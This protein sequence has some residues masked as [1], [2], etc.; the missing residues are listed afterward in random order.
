MYF[1]LKKTETGTS[2]SLNTVFI[3][4]NIDIRRSVESSYNLEKL[5][6]CFFGFLLN[7]SENFL[8]EQPLVF[9]LPRENQKVST[10]ALEVQVVLGKLQN[11]K[12]N[13]SKLFWRKKIKKKSKT[14]TRHTPK[15]GSMAKKSALF[16][17]VP[18]LG[19]APYGF[20]IIVF[21]LPQLWTNCLVEEIIHSFHGKIFAGNMYL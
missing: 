1:L 8:L 20:K 3:H 21:I 15:Q 5:V 18:C 17:C 19:R 10:L 13:F 11:G 14:Q 12:N 6:C 9:S 2:Y 4:W 7:F 16:G